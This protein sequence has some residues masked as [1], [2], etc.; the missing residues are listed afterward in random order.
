MDISIG[1]KEKDEYER[2]RGKR[3]VLPL[4]RTGSVGDEGA[5]VRIQ[6]EESKP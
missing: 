1:R 4:S 6:E 5:R 2:R 3:M